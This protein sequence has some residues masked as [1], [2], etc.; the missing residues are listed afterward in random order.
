MAATIKKLVW[1]WDRVGQKLWA[2]LITKEGQLIRVGF[3]LGHVS[4]I[5]DEE[6]GNCGIYEPAQVGDLESVDGFLSRVKRIGRKASRTVT[7]PKKL[8]GAATRAATR[9]YIP[10]SVFDRVAPKVVRRTQQRLAKQAVRLHRAGYSAAKKYGLK[11]ARS[12]QL[13][14]AL[15]ASAVAFPA[16]GGPALGA[17]MAAHRAA[18]VYDAGQAA[19]KQLQSG[20]RNQHLVSAVQRSA[21]VQRSVRQLPYASDPRARM[22]ASAFQSIP[23]RAPSYP[24]FPGF[25]SPYGYPQFGGY[26]Y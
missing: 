1:Q 16:V 15:G 25:Q 22:L 9:G 17:W 20:A 24:Q 18:Q 26:G 8:I 10:K 4:M 7:H 21:Q 23:S 12:K 14:A 11:A 13:G 2:N 5:F 6:L 19:R 3:P